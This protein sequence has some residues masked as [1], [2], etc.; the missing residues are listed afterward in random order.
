MNVI[1]VVH[2]VFYY[3]VSNVKDV[4]NIFLGLYYTV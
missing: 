4:S 1:P 2:L 3:S